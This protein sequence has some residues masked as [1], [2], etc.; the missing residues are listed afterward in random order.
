MVAADEDA[1]V[2]DFAESYGII[3]HRALPARLLATLAVG[4]RADSRIKMRL[5][6]T[7]VAQDTLLLA[8]AV[9]RL[10]F[11]AWAKTRDAQH[12]YNRP[13]SILTV[14][15]GDAGGGGAVKAYP[16][17]GEYEAAWERITG[18]KHGNG[19]G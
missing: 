19:T 16:S 12:G 9:D 15:M 14:L 13:P 17:A 10:S 1:L 6:G 3:D 4:L 8:A 2:C 5:S 11:L 18:V 7:Q